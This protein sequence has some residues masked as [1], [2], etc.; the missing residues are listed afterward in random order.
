MIIKK[1][2]GNYLV[3]GVSANELAKALEMFPWLTRVLEE[4]TT[5]KIVTPQHEPV[6]FSRVLSEFEKKNNDLS[7][8]TLINYRKYSERALNRFGTENIADIGGDK[9]HRFYDDL[10]SNEMLSKSSV[11]N[12]HD[13]LM[14]VFGYAVKQNYIDK[15]PAAELSEMIADYR[16]N[17]R[18]T[19]T[20]TTEEFVRFLELLSQTDDKHKAYF[21]MLLYTGK[22]R[23]E[24]LDVHWSDIDMDNKSITIGKSRIELM[25]DQLDLS[26][27]PAV[28]M[29]D[30]MIH[31]LQQWKEEQELIIEQAG[32]MWNEQ[33]YVFTNRDGNNMSGDSL[34]QWLKKFCVRNSLPEVSISGLQRSAKECFRTIGLKDFAALFATVPSVNEPTA[35]S[36]LEEKKSAVANEIGLRIMKLRTDLQMTKQAFSIPLGITPNAIRKWEAGKS[37]PA[38]AQLLRICSVTHCRLDELLGLDYEDEPDPASEKYIAYIKSLQEAGKPLPA[39]ATFVETCKQFHMNPNFLLAADTEDLMPEELLVPES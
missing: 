15:N 30:S 2:N 20:F 24:I 37:I 19:D 29:Y 28:S 11:A 18:V 10:R 9:I 23:D 4:Y 26:N 8:S 21:L 32:K 31:V 39:T 36:E 13:F 17:S 1:E 27:M 3:D 35:N 16:K 38:L 12:H 6:P 14:K 5:A 22:K 33:D 7:E 25:N 34:F